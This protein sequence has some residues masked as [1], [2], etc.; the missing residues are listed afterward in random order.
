MPLHFCEYINRWL[1]QYLYRIL[2]SECEM[3]SLLMVWLELER[4]AR[5]PREVV[6]IFL[7]RSGWVSVFAPPCIYEQCGQ[8]KAT[9][10]SN[11]SICIG[12]PN[13]VDWDTLRWMDLTTA[14][15]TSQWPDNCRPDMSALM[16]ANMTGWRVLL[17][18]TSV[19]KPKRG[20]DILSAGD[21]HSVSRDIRHDGT[22]L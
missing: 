22:S 12:S 18:I 1:F 13:V 3:K 7:T 9:E 20:A 14:T 2:G 15:I 10:K 5:L 8:L 6:G 19:R 4:V 16:C 21:G 11:Q 17:D